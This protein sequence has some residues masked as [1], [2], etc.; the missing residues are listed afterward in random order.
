MPPIR[1]SLASA[2]IRI[3]IP[4]LPMSS[5]ERLRSWTQGANASARMAAR[6]VFVRPVAA[7]LSEFMEPL[8]AAG[9]GK[10]TRRR[11]EPLAANFRQCF[12]L[13]CERRGADA[14]D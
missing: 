12:A 5:T 3:V 8:L 11:C 4:S 14:V 1:E 6:F 10:Q 2:G 13:F 7:A 9:H